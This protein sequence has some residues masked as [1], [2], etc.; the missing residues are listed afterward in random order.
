MGQTEGDKVE[1]IADHPIFRGLL[2]MGC[3]DFDA[4]VEGGRN[5]FSSQIAGFVGN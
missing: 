4:K 2:H 1:A 5:Y 3:L